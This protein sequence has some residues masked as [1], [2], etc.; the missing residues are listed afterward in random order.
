ML[1][2][3][4]TTPHI[5]SILTIYNLS[6]YSYGGEKNETLATI[7]ELINKNKIPLYIS[8]KSCFY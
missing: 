6:Y 8:L 1:K 2:K 7:L 4:N 5:P 3:K